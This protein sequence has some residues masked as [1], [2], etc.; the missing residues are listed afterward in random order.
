MH[1]AVSRDAMQVAVGQA[2]LGQRAEGDNALAQLGGSLFQAVFLHRAVQDGVAILV[3]D[4]RHMQL[5]QNG[6]GLF[7]R[8][9]VIIG[10]ACIQC[11]AA[12]HSLGQCAHRLLQRSLGVHAVVVENVHVVQPHAAQALIQAG[13]QVLAA[14]PIAVGAVPHRVSRLGGDDQL[15]AVGHQVVPQNFAKVGLGRARFRAVVVGQVKV[16]DA[17]VKGGTA[18]RPHVLVG[19]S[20]AKIVPQPQ[21]D[22][23]QQQ[24][25][26]AAAAVGQDS[27]TALVSLIH[28][29]GPP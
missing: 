14:A 23:R 2:A 8:W 5:I 10:Q 28:G 19:R 24:S 1:A 18:E 3:D 25:T 11:L 4:K 20:I 26:A 7:Q 17:V 16:G 12:A 15:V 13:Q 22:G 9:A 21:R 29:R 27:V 6:C